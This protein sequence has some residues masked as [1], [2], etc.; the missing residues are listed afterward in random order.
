MEPMTRYTCNTPGPNQGRTCLAGKMPSP[1][2]PVS[3]LAGVMLFSVEPGDYL[4]Q[5][6]D[7]RSFYGV[8][9]AT[10]AADFEPIP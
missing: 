6:E 3:A 1:P 10:F 9:E 4:L 5:W 2:T 7:D 8:S